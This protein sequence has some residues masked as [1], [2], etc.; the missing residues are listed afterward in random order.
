[1]EILIPVLDYS[2][3][4]KDCK[5]LREFSMDLITVLNVNPWMC[6]YIYLLKILSPFQ[7]NPLS[8]SKYLQSPTLLTLLFKNLD[9]SQS[10]N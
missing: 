5:C 3:R 6:I 4:V 10:M 9:T 7:K 1:M 2:W 8:L